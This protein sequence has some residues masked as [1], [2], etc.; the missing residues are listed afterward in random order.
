MLKRTLVVLG[1]MLV[2]GGIGWMALFWNQTERL[3]AECVPVEP[4]NLEPSR[5]DAALDS[6]TMSTMNGSP[7]RYLPEGTWTVSEDGADPGEPQSPDLQPAGVLEFEY[8][9]EE[10]DLLIATGNFW[11]FMLVTIDGQPANLLPKISGQK[12]VQE[13]AACGQ[14]DCMMLKQRLAQMGVV[15]YK[16]FYEPETQTDAEWRAGLPTKRWLRVH[17]EPNPS[18]EPRQVRIEVWRSWGQMPLRGV[19]VDAL[20]P[21]P[22][23]LWPGVLIMVA[24]FGLLGCVLDIRRLLNHSIGGWLTDSGGWF[25]RAVRGS[26][27]PLIT[28]SVPPTVYWAVA[29]LGGVVIAIAIMLQLWWLTLAG[30]GLLALTTLFCMTPWVAV[31][32]FGLPFYFGVTLPLLPGRAVALMDIG[33]WVGCGLM[34]VNWVVAQFRKPAGQ[35]SSTVASHQGR[36]TKEPRI[37]DGDPEGLISGHRFLYLCVALLTGWSLV[38]TFAASHFSVAFREWRTVFLTAALFALLL[39]YTLQVAVNRKQTRDLL[40]GA[41]LFGGTTVA[42][43]GL[44]Q[45]VSGNMLITA[46]GVSRVRALYG[47]PNNLALYLDRTLAVTLALGLLSQSVRLRWLWRGAALIQLAALLLTFSKGSLFLGLPAMLVAIAGVAWLRARGQLVPSVMARLG[48]SKRSVL[49]W[50]GGIGLASLLALLPFLGAERFQRLLDFSQGTSFLRLQLWQSAWQMALEH[51]WFG[52]GPD[53]FL[54]AFRTDYILPPAWQERDL[55]HPHNWFLDWWTRLGV[56]GFLLGMAFW[57]AGLWRAWIR[58]RHEMALNVGIVAA[59]ASAL[60]HGLTDVSYALPDLML[61]WI[62]LLL[63]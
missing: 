63:L 6:G 57:G 53:N 18:H 59:G 42:A 46:E 55:N 40:I 21:E 27:Q 20:P 52:V 37:R 10:L 35:V 49:I 61:V 45:Y 60:A 34:G 30:L 23:P 47:S 32:L 56:P 41:W 4:V 7:F 36:A 48:W 1:F 24:G 17:R 44:W 8:A 5:I 38:A 14:D 25:A 15:G 9:G 26:I 3:C 16:T 50:V 43:I 2:V 22:K 33:V 12:L 51:P 29:G 11:G 62:F 54:Y 58:S 19:A 31:L 13:G 39:S 28:Q